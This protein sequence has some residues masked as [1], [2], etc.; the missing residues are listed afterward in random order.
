M[1]NKILKKSV[2]GLISGIISGLFS[3]GGGLILIPAYTILFNS[4][5]KEA[6]ATSIFCILPMVFVSSVFFGVNN[7][8][9]WKIAI[10]C[11]IGGS[12]GG[13]IGSKLLNTLNPKYLKI[14]F[15][16]FL[17]YSSIKIIF[18]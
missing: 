15:I 5:E 16:L 6:K 8:I 1:K 10:L 4:S 13:Y 12:I 17:G 11:A 18:F 14:I 9:N 2:L 3:S 7:Y